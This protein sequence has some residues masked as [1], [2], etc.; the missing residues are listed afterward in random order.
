MKM[1]CV[2]FRQSV[3]PNRTVCCLGANMKKYVACEDCVD[4]SL[5][6]RLREY[7]FEVETVL[8]TLPGAVGNLAGSTISLQLKTTEAVKGS[9]STHWKG[10]NNNEI[11]T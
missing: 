2:Q 7:L 1:N 10:F 8:L 5:H 11:D 4:H 9:S 3:R 6:P